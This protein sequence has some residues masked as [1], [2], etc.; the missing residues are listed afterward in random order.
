M[1]KNDLKQR[2]EIDHVKEYMLSC[3]D[4]LYPTATKY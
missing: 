4:E 1:T 3:P 2:S